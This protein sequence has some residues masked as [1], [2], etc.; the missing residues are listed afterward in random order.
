[1]ASR[2]LRAFSYTLH[3]TLHLLSVLSAASSAG[4]SEN[5]PASAPA[6]SPGDDI[7]PDIPGIDYSVNITLPVVS[8]T[9]G[10]S[11]GPPVCFRQGLSPHP[12]PIPCG[13]DP[14]Q[15]ASSQTASRVSQ[16]LSL[17]SARQFAS[18][19]KFSR[20]LV[21]DSTPKLTPATELFD[22]CTG[23]ASVSVTL[24]PR[25]RDTWRGWGTSLCWLGNFVGG[26]P[27]EH[28]NPLMDLLFSPSGLNLNIVRYNIGGGY[29]ATNSP[30]QRRVLFAARARGAD[31]IDAFAN[32]P[33]W[34]MTVSG[35][36]AGAPI[37]GQGNLK[38]E[39]ETAFA[40]YL[41][42]VVQKFARDR[43]WGKGLVFDTLEPFNEALEGWWKQGG[44]QEGCNINIQ[45]MRRILPKVQTA[46]ARKQ[47][48]TK[49]AGVDSFVQTTPRQIGSI[50]S[51]FLIRYNV[52][53]YMSLAQNGTSPIEF[54]A[55]NFHVMKDI[56]K[57]QT[58]EV[59]VSEWGPM[60]RGG[61]DTDVALF[62]GRSI[63]ASL[64]ILE[65]TGIVVLG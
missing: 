23:Q 29:N 65:A 39:Y 40:E 21:D 24:K 52:H 10:D 22:I 38:V 18:S 25:R 36:V 50:L 27:E 3:L 57:S 58:K 61:E 45:Q 41:T 51:P 14:S 33:P 34:W 44:G 30:R 42:D 26:F 19:R 7:V 16:M 37:Y 63:I 12:V 28:F 13:D 9:S 4:L 2:N 54:T 46:L 5:A 8:G 11:V 55:Q 6:P 62:M 59:F 48:K 17:A 35:D 20:P 49:I 64:N 53:G 47:L 1:M 60:Q 31:R 32:S 56:A 43:S 15:T